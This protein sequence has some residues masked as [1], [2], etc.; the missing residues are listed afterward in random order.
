MKPTPFGE[1]I[2][3]TTRHFIPFFS[4]P[5]A[6]NALDVLLQSSSIERRERRV[7]GER[8]EDVGRRR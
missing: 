4:I 5:V 6:F 1:S 2:F 3:P 8:I 7:V